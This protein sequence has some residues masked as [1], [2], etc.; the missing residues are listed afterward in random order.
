MVAEQDGQAPAGAEKRAE[1]IKHRLVPLDDRLE[2]IDGGLWVSREGRPSSG[3]ASSRGRQ[4]AL[5]EKINRIAIE[6]N[7]ARAISANLLGSLLDEAHDGVRV[8]AQ[9]EAALFRRRRIITSQ[10]KI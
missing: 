9:A 3:L 1:G 5:G 10:M 2:L 4:I 7:F 6:H 8:S